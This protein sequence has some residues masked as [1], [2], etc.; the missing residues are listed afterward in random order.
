[1]LLNGS[2][3]KIFEVSCTVLPNC[4]QSSSIQSSI[5]LPISRLYIRDL[6]EIVKITKDGAESK[7]ILNYG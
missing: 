1:M 4:C 3:S 6:F 2:G 5:I 7:V